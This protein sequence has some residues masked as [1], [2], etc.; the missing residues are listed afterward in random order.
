MNHP[1]CG[2]LFCS[3]LSSAVVLLHATAARADENEGDHHGG[4][5]SLNLAA[6][7]EGAAVVESPHTPSGNSLGAGTGFKGRVG[8][9]FHVPLVRFTPEVGYGY[10]RF[11]AASTSGT[12][13]DWDAHRIIGGVRVGL[14]EIIVPTIYGHAGYGWRATGDPSVPNAGGATFDAGLALDLHLLPIIGFGAHAEYTYLDAR[15]YVPQW[16]AFGLHMS[17]TL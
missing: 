13:Y 3:A 16:L 12:T 11:F 17:L 7:V 15:P 10:S 9:Q 4:G 1:R 2:F 8:E 14:G 6:D 5:G